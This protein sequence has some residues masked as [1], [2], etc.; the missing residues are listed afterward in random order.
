MSTIT[1]IKMVNKETF[2]PP[3]AYRPMY[4]A[5]VI[6]FFV[7]FFSAFETKEITINEDMTTKGIKAVSILF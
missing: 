2:P 3:G 1:N 5:I 6:P 4:Q 7:I